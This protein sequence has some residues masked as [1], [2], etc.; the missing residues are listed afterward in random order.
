MDVLLSDDVKKRHYI[1]GLGSND[2]AE[3]Q[4]A[5]MIEALL[6]EFSEIL[7][8]PVCQTAPSHGEGPDYLNAVVSLNSSLSFSDLRSTCK[9]IEARLGRVRPSPVCAAD[10]DILAVWEKPEKT[11]AASFIS[12]PYLQPL[13]DVVLQPLNLFSGSEQAI[14]AQS[15]VTVLLSDGRKVGQQ[16]VQ[17]MARSEVVC[18]SM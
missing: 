7:L 18:D 16:V 14:N 10:I 5:A 4:M 1:L 6:Q 12:E 17:L 8:S 9:S 15:L 3:E 2:N 13:V 11:S